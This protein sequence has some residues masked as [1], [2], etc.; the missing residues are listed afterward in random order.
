[1]TTTAAHSLFD[2]LRPR[3][4]FVRR[5]VVAL[6]GVGLVF[7]L[8]VFLC[9]RSGFMLVQAGSSGE[10]SQEPPAGTAPVTR[11]R[12]SLVL[13]Q[14]GALDCARQSVLTSKVEWNT[15][16]TSI[17]PEGTWVHQGD[18]VATLD[19]SKLKDE[20]GE[21]QVDVLKAETAVGTAQQNLKIQ[22][23]ENTNAILKAKTASD[24]AKMTLDAFAKAEF[25]KQVSDLESQIAK[26]LDSF[27]SAGEQLEYTERQVRKGFRTVVDV[28]RDRLA[29]L[30]A[31]ESHED[32]VEQLRVLK[33]HTYARRLS[34]LQGL[35]QTA[36]NAV[37]Q[38]T[39][40][41]KTKLLSRHM[42]LDIQQRGL[43]RQTQ[44]FEWAKKMLGFCEIRAPHDGQVMYCNEDRGPDDQISEGMTVRFRQSLVVIPDR[45][46]MQI[47][48]RVHESLRRLLSVGMPA[49]IR[50][51]SSPDQKLAG[52]VGKV[53]SFPLSGR[54]PNRDLR[55]YEA[56]VE[57]D[58]DCEELTPGLSAH[59]DLVAA[60]KTDALQ[61]PV[62]AV[63][64][65]GDRYMAFVASGEEVVPREVFV[66][67]STKEHVEILGGLDEGERVV[68]NPRERCPD[69][70]I[71][72]E[73]TPETSDEGHALVAD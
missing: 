31:K 54:W 67:E 3:R 50:L 42:Q 10:A 34:E 27:H 28:D 9:G 30:K 11:G 73:G 46:H 6:A 1:M 5:G 43:L 58:G 65:I 38:Q 15:K 39:A 56:V 60:S 18:V 29:L 68:V 21:E 19:V 35:A 24:I 40:L 17:V 25:P 49:V 48:V 32:L 13:T 37:E 45:T 41:A 16:L 22:E 69:A 62:G 52:R 7:G 51:D 64:E 47:A 12:L 59:V 57:L 14:R 61:I 63:T 44:Q 33:E 36:L 23:I 4:T 55:E 8:A 20:W 53:S 2:V 72:C 26:A 66:G 70:V 71:A